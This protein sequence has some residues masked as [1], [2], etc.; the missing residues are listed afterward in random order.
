M[1]PLLKIFNVFFWSHFAAQ[2]VERFSCWAP[3]R[4]LL[5]AAL[6]EAGI[7]RQGRPSNFGYLSLDSASDELL[8]DANAWH[9]YMADSDAY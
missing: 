9:V 6:A 5:A 1:N 7:A 3:V 8:S 2:E 4:S